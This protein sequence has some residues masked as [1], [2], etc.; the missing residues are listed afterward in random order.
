[1]IEYTNEIEYFVSLS[2]GESNL[3]VS[4]T[5]VNIVGMGPSNETNVTINGSSASKEN[6]Y[7]FITKI[8]P[9]FIY[10][11]NYIIIYSSQD[12]QLHNHHYMFVHRNSNVALAITALSIDDMHADGM[13]FIYMIFLGTL[14][15]CDYNYSLISRLSLIVL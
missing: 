8:L 3:T 10:N 7:I 5:A 4:V 14:I 15:L 2:G 6:N 9:N 13:P 12:G 1:M 11:I